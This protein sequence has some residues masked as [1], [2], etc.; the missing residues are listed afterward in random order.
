M[1]SDPRPKDERL[2]PDAGFWIR[3]LSGFSVLLLL[4]ALH[5][6]ELTLPR[7]DNLGRGVASAGPA[8]CRANAGAPIGGPFELVNQYGQTVTA[9]DLKG[10]PALVFFGFTYCPDVCPMTLARLDVAIEQAGP[11]ARDAYQVVMISVDPERDTP[12]QM[13]A[14]LS[15][16]AFPDGIIGLTGTPEQIDAAAKAYKAAYAKVDAP[17]SVAGYTMDHSSFIY[18]MEPDGGFEGLITHNQTPDEI[19]QCLRQYLRNDP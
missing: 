1:S 5:G 4:G 2:S 12:E 15:I 10:R 18:A 6:A 16:E 3:F 13:A 9:D 8:S 17:D 19:A 11:R 7:W 14:Y